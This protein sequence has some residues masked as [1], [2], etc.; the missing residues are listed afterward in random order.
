[1]NESWRYCRDCAATT[2]RCPAH[3]SWVELIPAITIVP[4]TVI[5]PAQII[6]TW[7]LMPVSPTSTAIRGSV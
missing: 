1:M 3:S 6:P 7:P 2:F 5:V 4:E